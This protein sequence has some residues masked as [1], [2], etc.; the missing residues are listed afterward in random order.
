M[1]WLLLIKNQCNITGSLLYYR[2]DT[3]FEILILITI[4][5]ILKNDMAIGICL[6]FRPQIQKY[7]L[8]E[9][10]DDN[11]RKHIGDEKEMFE[12]GSG[13]TQEMN[14]CL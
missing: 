3:S 12:E 4:V 2:S 8:Q 7:V 10:F 13:L 1:I 11:F 6:D 14:N 9:E 5:M